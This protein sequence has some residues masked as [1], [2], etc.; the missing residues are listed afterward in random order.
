MHI[1]CVKMM[2]HYAMKFRVQV[3]TH[4]Q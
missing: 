1:F 4:V 3:C 2:F